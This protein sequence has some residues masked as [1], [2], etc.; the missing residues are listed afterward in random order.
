MTALDPAA[1]RLA[2]GS[3]LAP[4]LY[5]IGPDDA[6]LALDLMQAPPAE[7]PGV[8][9]R[10]VTVPT[11]YGPMT[12]HVLTPAGPATGVVLYAHGGGWMIGGFA[13]HH[14]LAVTLCR[15]TGAV[16][17]VPEYARSPE[18]RHPVAVDQLAAT[19]DWVR[20]G[21]LAEPVDVGRIVAVGDCAGATMVLAVALAER[22]DRRLLAQVL[23]Y[24]IGRPDPGDASAAEFATG[25]VLRLTDVRRL[26][27]AYAPRAEAAADPLGATEVAALPPTLLVTAEADVTRDRAE[28]LGGRMRAAGVPVTTVRY[29]GTVHDFAVLDALR[30][31]PAARA[32][33]AQTT[34]YLRTVLAGDA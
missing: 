15:D 25:A 18:A 20:D 9:H 21:G 3:R 28:R 34:T 11:P 6:R 5:G 8:G 13:T 14:R 17:V 24:P 29:L 30:W 23:L 1:R 19:L 12:A 22:G 10:V 4:H 31:T 27:L 32:V 2:E 7:T 26:C 33:L 16:V